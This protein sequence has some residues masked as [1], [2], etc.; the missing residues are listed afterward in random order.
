MFHRL[1]ES[2]LD[3]SVMQTKWY[4]VNEV[5]HMINEPITHITT[6]NNYYTFYKFIN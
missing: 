4:K 3:T 1:Y 2:G 6:M 5:G